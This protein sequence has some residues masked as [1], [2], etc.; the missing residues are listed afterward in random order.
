MPECKFTA[1][2]FKMFV[3]KSH[4]ERVPYPILYFLFLFLQYNMLPLQYKKRL[5]EIKETS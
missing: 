3:T 4:M 5:K 2:K 1:S